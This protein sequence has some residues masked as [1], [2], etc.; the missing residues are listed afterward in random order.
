M[1]SIQEIDLSEDRLLAIAADCIEKHNLIG[2]LKMLNKNAATSGNSEESY[3]MY[4]EIF[5]DMGLY[6]KCVN[7]W[8]KYIDYVQNFNY[9][10]DLSDAYEGLAISFM[11]MGQDNFAAYYYNKLLLETDAELSPESRQDI[12]NDF[13]AVEKPTLKFAYPPRLADY[14]EV[15]ENGISFMR[16][17][18]YEKAVQEFE[19][20]DEGNEKY[21]S[22]RNFIAMCK[23]IC[24]KCEEA[25]EEC[26][27]I[28]NKAPDDVQALTTLAAVKNQQ[29]KS[30]ESVQLAKRL[31]SLNVTSTEELYKIATVCCENGMHDDAY[32]IFL[33]LEGELQYDCNLLYFKA[34]SAYNSGRINE[35]LDAFDRLLT[36]YPNAVSAKYYYGFVRRNKDTDDYKDNPLSYFYR[37]PQDQRESNLQVLS[38]FT[39]LSDSAASRVLQEVD[40][41]E[42][43]SWCFDEGEGS[44]APELNLLGAICAVK[45]PQCDDLLRDILLD[46]SLSDSLK[47]QTIAAIAER[48]VESSYGVVV[49]NI[50]RRLNIPALEIPRNK[51]KRF[52]R[53]YAVLISRFAM[54]NPDYSYL[55]NAAAS[56]L[57]FA[58]ER[59]QLLDAAKDASTLTA[60]IFKLSGIR[61]AGI[62][63]KNICEFFGAKEQTYKQMLSCL[64]G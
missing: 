55:I 41:S 56:K 18:D 12:I 44:S 61:E 22:A 13:L 51:K 43:I 53:A 57:Y 11:N 1:S 15:I 38:A 50:Y 4:A 8:F 14:T 25:E 21:N 42:C 37:L 3:M 26:L 10:T 62:T 46:A 48:N 30:E 64:K 58:L 47:M 9:D 27:N 28:L 60:A 36:I 49:C 63:D 40:I 2:A 20:V 54:L 35:S 32:K 29:K 34:V 39:R 59:T 52:V 16:D 23:I 6:E 7:G 33:K 5:D 45:T 19:K 31:L 24:D 17:N